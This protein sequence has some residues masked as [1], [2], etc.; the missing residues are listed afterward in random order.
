MSSARYPGGIR[1]K[2]SLKLK[3]V[4]PLVFRITFTLQTV[5]LSAKGTQKII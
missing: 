3:I 1:I 4:I 5:Y 2:E